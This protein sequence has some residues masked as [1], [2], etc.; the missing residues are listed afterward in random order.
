MLQSITDDG[1]IIPISGAEPLR[2][3]LYADDVCVFTGIG[4]N[5]WRHAP[6]FVPKSF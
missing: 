1:S 5:N 6:V 4:V 2:S 3:T